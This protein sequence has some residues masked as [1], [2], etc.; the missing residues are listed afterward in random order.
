MIIQDTEVFF[1]SANDFSALSEK[2]TSF[3]DV[4]PVREYFAF[5]K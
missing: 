3:N 4:F 5:L 2:D 1:N